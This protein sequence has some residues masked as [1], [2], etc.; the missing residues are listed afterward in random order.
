MTISRITVIGAGAMGS[1]IAYISAVAGYKVSLVEQNEGFLEKGVDRIRK[2]LMDGIDRKKM[3]PAEG[4]KIYG[5]LKTTVSLEEGVK[6]TDLVIEAITENLDIKKSVFSQ[7][8]KLTS[9]EVILATNTSTIS[10]TEI[11]KAVS[12]NKARVIGMHFFNPPAAMKLVEI[13][14]GEHTSQEVIKNCK[15]VA[16]KLDKNPVQAKDSPG[17]I[18]NRVLVP[19]LNEAI[20]L[21]DE[22][23]ASKED[24]DLALTLGANFPVGPLTLADFVGLDVALASMRTL[25][26]KFGKAYS[27]SPSLIKLVKENKLGLKTGQGFYNYTG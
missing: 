4:E 7:L 26:N 19:V 21:L 13:I 17:F 18:V 14:T 23:V 24:I 8:D 12:T 27:P 9:P 2:M 3:T 10:I 11:S 5:R 16:K 22:G 20:K 15:E 25:E 6:E 1:G